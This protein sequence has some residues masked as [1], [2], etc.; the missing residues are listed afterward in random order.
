[1]RCVWR[2][3]WEFESPRVQFLELKCLFNPVKNTS[4]LIKSPNKTQKCVIDADAFISFHFSLLHAGFVP[5]IAFIWSA[6]SK[7]KQRKVTSMKMK[8][9]KQNHKSIEI[10]GRLIPVEV[11]ESLEY[12]LRLLAQFDGETMEEYILTA[13]GS[14]MDTDLEWWTT[15]DNPKSMANTPEGKLAE[16]RWK[17]RSELISEYQKKKGNK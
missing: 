8:T 6:K 3:P 16:E 14:R 7:N 4:V 5:A 17:A 10:K 15:Y 12:I 2:N 9:R 1:L 11:P 13:L